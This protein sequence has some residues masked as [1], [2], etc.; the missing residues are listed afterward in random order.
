[1]NSVV[2]QLGNVARLFENFS[3]LH[4]I[5]TFISIIH[6]YIHAECRFVRFRRKKAKVTLKFLGGDETKS[7]FNHVV[8]TVTNTNLCHFEKTLMADFHT[9]N[10]PLFLLLLKQPKK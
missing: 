10:P 8:G 5:P 1:M 7:L 9:L 4:A 3:L 6:K 2:T